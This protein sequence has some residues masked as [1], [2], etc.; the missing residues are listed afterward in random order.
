MVEINFVGD[1]ALFQE[2]EKHHHDP[3][4]SVILPDSSFNVANFEFPVPSDSK[5]KKFFDVDENYCVSDTFGRNVN[6]GKFNLYGLA[7]NH[8]LD[9]GYAGLE[10]TINIIEGNGSD[11]FGVGRAPLNTFSCCLNGI[12]FL[13][14]ACVKKGRWSKI[15]GEVG[16]DDYN[17]S[18]LFEKIKV[19]K[20]HP[21]YDHIVVF[22]HWGTELVDCPDPLDVVNARKMIDAGASCVIGHHPHVS[23]GC[24]NYKNGIIAYSLGSFIYLPEFEKGNFDHLIDRDVSICLN[25]KFSKESVEGYIPYKYEL[26][27]STLTTV[28]KGDFRGEEKFTKIC[29]SIGDSKIYYKK[30]RSILLKRELHAFWVRFKS[31]PI[32]A[33]FHYI[34]YIRLKHF[35][36]I[37]GF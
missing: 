3:I 36:K 32:R 33:F 9:Y 21:G 31:A 35:K 25:V 14:I 37:L 34:K 17:I 27:K 8:C 26:D 15:S 24:E 18:M 2:F 6:I 1:V 7:N 13:F 19:L 10:N 12:K 4:D 28:C 11:F 5:K 20:K 30:L 29:R 16:P 23:Q 22:P